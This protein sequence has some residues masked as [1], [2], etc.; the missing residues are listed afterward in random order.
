MISVA[1]NIREL[2][3]PIGS[4]PNV[5]AI[6][7]FVGEQAVSFCGWMAFGI[8]FCVCLLAI[9]LI[10]LVDLQPSR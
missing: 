3:T 5:F 7:Y 8:P 2:G 4:P 6:V 9:A 1:A 10:L